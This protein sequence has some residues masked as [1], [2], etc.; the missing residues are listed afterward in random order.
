M[1]STK[2]FIQRLKNLD[3]KKSSTY[4]ILGSI[5]LLVLIIMSFSMLL[6]GDSASTPLITTKLRAALLTYK[7]TIIIKG[8]TPTPL[9]S[10]GLPGQVGELTPTGQKT[11]PTSI[12]IATRTP[13][14]ATN[15]P[16]EDDVT[17]TDTVIFDDNNPEDSVTV[18]PTETPADLL[19]EAATETPAEEI[20]EEESPTQAAT[21][22][23]TGSVQYPIILFISA[24]VF[25]FISFLF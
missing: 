16:V 11:L 22:P 23:E 15:A 25:L 4:I 12:P 14:S 10:G 21:L 17:P 20:T 6:R 18:D 1:V 5:L 9:G 2:M 8:A 7:R 24:T 3:R 19:A 13:D